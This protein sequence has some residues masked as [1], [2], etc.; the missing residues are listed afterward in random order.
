[1]A[2][3]GLYVLLRYVTAVR[4]STGTTARRTRGVVRCRLRRPDLGHIRRQQLTHPPVH[5]LLYRLVGRGPGR[6]GGR[7]ATERP[8]AAGI[9]T[10][11]HGSGGHTHQAVGPLQVATQEL[12]CSKCH[13][14]S[15]Q[16]HK[17][18]PKFRT[19]F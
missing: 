4:R 12:C 11:H 2:R 7:V 5:R 8:Q 13:L 9:I 3:E 6:A 14:S 19:N 16:N 1:M 10:R 18:R 17:F 15:V